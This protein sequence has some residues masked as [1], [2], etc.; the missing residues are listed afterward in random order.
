M[1][2][3]IAAL[4]GSRNVLAGCAVREDLLM[5]APDYAH[6]VAAQSSLIVAE[7]A[8]KWSA[9]RPDIGSYNFAAADHIVNFAQRHGIQMRG[10]N[11]V[12]HEALPDWFAASVT[13]ENARDV[14]SAHIRT[15]MG[16]YAGRMHSWDVVNEAINTESE[17]PDGLRD[18]PWLRLIG[19][20][21]IDF[22][23]RAARTADPY[24]LLTYNEFGI[25][26]E[27][28]A[29]A[30]KR[31]LTLEMLR[32][33]RA[34]DVPIDAI[35]I[36]SHLRAGTRES[37]GD[38]LRG[39]IR[40]CRSLGLHVFVTE[41]DVDDSRLPD[42]VPLRDAAVAK[43]YGDY[44]NLVL[45]EDASAIVMW[46]ITDRY[47]WLDKAK[48]RAGR[49]HPRPLP[50]DEKMRPAPAFYSITNALKKV[51]TSPIVQGV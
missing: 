43:I 24:A 21:Y 51:R 23:F 16:R 25:E 41:L 27:S 10:H 7:N 46:G 33:L 12:W 14:L 50:F 36:Q 48:P 9:L 38:G 18:T 44:L 13:H 28:D 45:E 5:H 29:D 42:D 35:G 31:T 30:V 19:D 20:D 26:Y 2:E 11:L 4:A 3:S 22:S 6:L 1:P 49:A 34:R 37:F 17:R 32:G 40:Q 39:F 8:M 47:T 15:V